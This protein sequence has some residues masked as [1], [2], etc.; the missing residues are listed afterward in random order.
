MMSVGRLCGRGLDDAFAIFGRSRCSARLCWRVDSSKCGGQGRRILG[1]DLTPIV[2]LWRFSR[3][4]GGDRWR[5]AEVVRTD[6]AQVEREPLEGRHDVDGHWQAIVGCVRRASEH[7]F[8]VGSDSEYLRNMKEERRRLLRERVALR[9]RSLCGPQAPVHQR[10]HDFHIRRLTHDVRRWSRRL[11]SAWRGRRIAEC[12]RISNRL[13]GQRSGT[14]GRPQGPCQEFDQTRPRGGSCGGRIADSTYFDR[15]V[16]QLVGSYDDLALAY[17]EHH[18]RGR[19]TRG[20]SPL[21]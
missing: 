11:W 1:H 19:W 4:G 16:E 18:L 8:S 6:F 2:S 21:C 15:E 20:A 9:A 5:F 13:S 7:I 14:K 3:G 12:Y 17:S 10:G